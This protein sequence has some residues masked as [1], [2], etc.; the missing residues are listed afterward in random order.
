MSVNGAGTALGNDILGNRTSLGSSVSYGWDCLNRMTS[1]NG[2]TATAYGYRA[3]G[4]RVSRTQGSN[5]DRFR[6]DGHMPMETVQAIGTAQTIENGLGAR[7]IDWTSVTTGSGTNILFPLYDAH[8]NQVATVARSGSNYVLAN[9]RLFGAWG[10]I[11]Q[12]ATSGS[13]SSRYC[14]NLGHVQDD[15]S[16]L[17][18]TRARYFEPGTGRYLSQGEGCECCNC[19]T[20]ALDNPILL[21]DGSGDY[22]LE[23]VRAIIKFLLGEAVMNIIN[24][25][26]SNLANLTKYLN[27][28]EAMADG[29]LNIPGKR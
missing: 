21:A 8:G 13:P 2:G 5:T 6:Y 28:M 1:F 24:A 18:Y 19:C 20:Y 11:R 14:A 15:E 3:D 23:L 9:Q 22:V 29:G 27:Q 7:G 10:E 17:I 16:G 4:M 25:K 12:G 26:L